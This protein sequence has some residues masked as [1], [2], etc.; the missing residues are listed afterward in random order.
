MTEQVPLNAKCINM[1]GKVPKDADFTVVRTQLVETNSLCKICPSGSL[2]DVAW[3]S[4]AFAPWNIRKFSN[5]N[6]QALVISEITSRVTTI[7]PDVAGQYLVHIRLFEGTE[8]LVYYG[9]AYV[10]LRVSWN[11]TGPP[12]NVELIISNIA[13]VIDSVDVMV[14]DNGFYLEQTIDA[15][16]IPI[17]MTGVVTIEMI[18]PNNS[19]TAH[20]TIP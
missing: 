15:S 19:T 7:M 5:L 4:Q 12:T 2:C 14:I 16:Y 17:T 13:G 9:S 11:G 1:F 18:G 6:T 8:D 10:E 20:I 3:F